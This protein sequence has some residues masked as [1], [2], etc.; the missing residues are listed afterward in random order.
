[1]GQKVYPIVNGMKIFIIKLTGN[2]KKNWGKVIFP[3]EKNY[4]LQQIEE[5]QI[6]ALGIKHRS[7]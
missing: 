5:I 2:V 4:F 1:M 7:I 6:T 3:C